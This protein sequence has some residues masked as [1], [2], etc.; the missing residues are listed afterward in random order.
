MTTE[1]IDFYSTSIKAPQQS[2]FA[3]RRHYEAGNQTTY[4]LGIGPFM[5]SDHGQQQIEL[6]G[7]SNLPKDGSKIQNGITPV[8]KLHSMSTITA[9][10]KLLVNNTKIVVSTQQ[11]VNSQYIFYMMI[12]SFC[13]V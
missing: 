7:T 12:F 8:K 5:L 6:N 10:S 3:P 11:I 4:I 1:T 2:G 13:T 9:G